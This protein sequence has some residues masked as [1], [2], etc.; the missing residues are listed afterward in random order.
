MQVVQWQC[1]Q[2]WCT[3][4]FQLL[5]PHLKGFSGRFC[6]LL[7]ASNNND[8]TLA[9]TC[10]W[11]NFP[12]SCRGACPIH[13]GFTTVG[14]LDLNIVQWRDTLYI[15]TLRSHDVSMV[16]LGNDTIDGNHRFQILD[17]LQ[18]ALLG[19]L[20]AVFCALQDDT[21]GVGATA[22]EADQHSTIITGNLV[23][24]FSSPGDEVSV[25][26]GVYKHFTFNNFVLK[27]NSDVR[28]SV[29]PFWFKTSHIY[30]PWSW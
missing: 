4:Y 25:V 3:W 28:L 12:I 23:K 19:P 26:F 2:S 9:R 30:S 27:V 13:H 11:G 7:L 16:L 18:N 17:N 14:E 8:V 1:F 21:V 6:I 24:N 15:H 29:T 10:R 5:F 20:H 22:R